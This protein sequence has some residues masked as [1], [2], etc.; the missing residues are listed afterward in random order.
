MTSNQQ[1]FDSTAEPATDLDAEVSELQLT[2]DF[3]DDLQTLC[4]WDHGIVLTSYVKILK[5]AYTHSED[6]HWKHTI[7]WLTGELTH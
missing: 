7:C 5:R 2:E 6:T 1:R 3:V 4:V